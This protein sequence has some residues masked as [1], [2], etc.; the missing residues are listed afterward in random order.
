[1]SKLNLFVYDSSL[2]YFVQL[3][4]FILNIFLNISA[5]TSSTTML[6]VKTITMNGIKRRRKN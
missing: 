6:W 1:M 2:Y 4:K 5:D 3:F